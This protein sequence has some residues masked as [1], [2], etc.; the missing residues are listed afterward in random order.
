MPYKQL[1][2]EF[3]WFFKS[4][5]IFDW[6]FFIMLLKVVFFSQNIL[7]MCMFSFLEK[8]QHR[9]QWDMDQ[10]AKDLLGN[11]LDQKRL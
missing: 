2:E 6:Q 10:V 8:A 11:A 3:V 1:A 5:R 4:L 9:P 7:Q